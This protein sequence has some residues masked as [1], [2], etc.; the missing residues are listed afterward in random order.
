MLLA[1]D[2]RPLLD[3]FESG[4][5]VYVKAMVDE[6]LKCP[7]VEL[8]LFYQAHQPCG[9]I[10]DRFPAVRYVSLSNSRFHAQ[11]LMSFP[12]LPKNY[13]PRRPDLI[14]LPDRRPFFSSDIPVVMTIHDMVPEQHQ[15][16]L[17]LKSKLWHRLFSMRRLERFC[18]GLLFPSLT[19]ANRAFTEL[20]WEVTYEGALL[21]AREKKPRG[22]AFKDPFVLSVSPL[23]PRKR[24]VWVFEMAKRFPKQEFV[25]AGIKL[26]DSRFSSLKIPQLPNL[27]LLTT[28]TEEEK[29]WLYRHASVLL[30]LSSEEGFDLP[31]LEAVAAKTPVILSDIPVH[32]EL[33]KNACFVKD[34]TECHAAL[35]S[36][37]QGHGK[38]PQPRGHYTWEKAAE[39]ALLFFLRVL[40]DKNGKR[41]GDGNGH[42][43]SHDA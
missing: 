24:L 42:D 22:I 16:T 17:S 10:H 18:S 15:S 14:W 21:A 35:Y 33:Y 32:H 12:P 39:R 13:F 19:V 5:T 3:P 4:V 1:V 41:R 7:S 26:K 23:D 43:H 31:V 40:R 38:V 11:S 9:S 20:P 29:T 27:H 37:L 30:A 28:F 8:D 34:E 36:A 6:L 2:L 25:C